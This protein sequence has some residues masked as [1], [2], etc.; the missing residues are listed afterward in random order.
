MKLTKR[1]WFIFLLL[2][3]FVLVASIFLVPTCS[4]LNVTVRLVGP[5][6]KKKDGS[7]QLRLAV[8]N[9][10][11][12]GRWCGGLFFEER[13]KVGK[14]TG[15]YYPVPISQFD[16]APGKGSEFNFVLAAD[17]P[18]NCRIIVEHYRNIAG[19]E[20]R[21]DSWLLF[22]EKLRR[23]YPERKGEFTTSEWL[24][25]TRTSTDDPEIR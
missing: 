19:L 18:K 15:L 13:D 4:R 12:Y 10:S 6:V 24:D 11:H 5:T 8:T 17:T 23:T 20:N 22:H 25:L 1:K 9:V 16:L 3:V 14:A 7:Y 21:L 2:L